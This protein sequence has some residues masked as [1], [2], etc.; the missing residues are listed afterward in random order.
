MLMIYG[1]ANSINVMKVLWV[2]EEL[3]CQFRRVDAG[4]EHGKVDDADFRAMNPNGR[5][6][7]INDDGFVLWE[8]NAIVRYLAYKYGL[9]TM[10]PADVRQRAEAEQWME[11]QQTTVAPHLAWPFH[12]IIRRVPA[13]RNEARMQQ[14]ADD[15]SDL[16]SVL[17]A[18]L[19]DRDYILG[20]R[21]TMADIPL[22][23]ATWRWLNLPIKRAELA[24]VEA[25]HERLL[26]REGFRQHVAHPLS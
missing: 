22:G 16:Y 21:L 3:G 26:N 17:D 8:S 1:R 25:W 4:M 14:A 12:G 6:P 24:H 11:W 10:Y 2:C 15:L 19:S 5:V 9:G 13:F 20:D 18:H 7:V 23:V